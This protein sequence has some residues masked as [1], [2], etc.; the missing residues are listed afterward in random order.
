L[1][2]VFINQDTDGYEVNQLGKQAARSVPISLP[3]ESAALAHDNMITRQFFPLNN[4]Q[5]HAVDQLKRVFGN[6]G[7]KAAARN[8]TFLDALILEHRWRGGELRPAIACRDAVRL[9]FDPSYTPSPA[10]AEIARSVGVGGSAP[11]VPRR[12]VRRSHER[13]RE[14]GA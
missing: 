12:Q 11:R 9:V 2:Y 8:Q 3:Y 6:G 7:P 10:V 1:W 4:R 13:E 14:V 5:L